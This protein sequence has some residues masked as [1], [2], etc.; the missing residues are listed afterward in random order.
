[1]LQVERKECSGASRAT[2][3]LLGARRQAILIVRLPALE[4]R[5]PAKA[6]L[7]FKLNLLT[8]GNLVLR[9]YTLLAAK[10][11]PTLPSRKKK[12]PRRARTV[13]R[14]DGRT[15]LRQAK[16]FNGGYYEAYS[17]RMYMSW[18]AGE[19]AF[20]LRTFS[21]PSSIHFFRKYPMGRVLATAP[22][23]D[24]FSGRG[25]QYEFSPG[26][27]GRLALCQRTSGRVFH[28]LTVQ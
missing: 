13:D 14:K 28:A 18:G 20:L 6:A 11:G 21:I 19:L 26:S 8:T 22:P 24:R 12:T 5:H 9:R 3:W 23:S 25:F 10:R 17:Q 4:R 27:E 7:A 16:L 15:P 1:M 2:R